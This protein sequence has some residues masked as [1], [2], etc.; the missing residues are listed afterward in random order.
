MLLILW[1]CEPLGW[2]KLLVTIL[3]KEYETNALE[4]VQTSRTRYLAG[5]SLLSICL[6]PKSALAE[7][8]RHL[9]CLNYIGRIHSWE[10]DSYS[11]GR[12]IRC[13]L[14]NQKFHYCVY[15]N[16]PLVPTLSKFNPFHTLSSDCL[17]INFNIILPS[18]YSSVF[19]VV[20]FP[21]GF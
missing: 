20:I 3:R 17:K 5:H 8:N 6:D 10:F 14:W 13:L 15:K 4:N 9:K 21:S 19:Q 11:D 16:P 7:G 18:I 12:E 1:Y 2:R